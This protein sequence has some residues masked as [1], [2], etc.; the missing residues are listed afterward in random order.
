[1]LQV[2][3]DKAT[4]DYVKMIDNNSKEKKTR[5]GEE[6]AFSYLFYA[7]S[8]SCWTSALYIIYFAL[9]RKCPHFK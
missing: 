3:I 1:M 5:A 8:I 2:M 4:S 6:S 9:L 7:Y